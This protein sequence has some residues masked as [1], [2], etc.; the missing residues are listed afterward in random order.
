MVYRS[1][2]AQLRPY[3]PMLMEITARGFSSA[4]DRHQ[5]LDAFP[6]LEPDVM[7]RAALVVSLFAVLI[8][9]CMSLAPAES[10]ELAAL[11]RESVQTGDVPGRIISFLRTGDDAGQ[12]VLLIH[13][14]PGSGSQWESFLLHPPS[15]FEIVAPDRLGFGLSVTRAATGAE[16]SHAAVPNFADQAKSLA[17][18]LVERNGRGTI[19]VGH[20]LGGPIAARLAAEYPDCVAGLVILAGSLDPELEEWH[21]YNELASWWIVQ[22]LLP[23]ELVRANREVA[24]ADKE[25]RELRPLLSRIRCPVI[26]IHGT[27]DELVPVANADYASRELKNAARVESVILTGE[28]HFLPWRREREIREAIARLSPP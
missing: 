28:G 19:V 15:G 10:R 1:L 21:W 18:L 4:A 22:W 16:P 13:G 9:G 24:R 11:Q 12:R 14:T 8:G 7:T 17:S 5:M 25:T 26:I 3:T 2:K 27:A 23:D 6:V 20:S